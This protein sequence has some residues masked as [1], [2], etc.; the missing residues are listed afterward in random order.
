MPM[1]GET[2]AVSSVAYAELPSHMKPLRYCNSCRVGMMATQTSTSKG[3]SKGSLQ[4]VTAP[5]RKPQEED[6]RWRR[7]PL[8]APLGEMSHRGAVREKVALDSVN[9][10]G[11]PM[12]ALS[13]SEG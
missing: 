12:R 6:D 1:T 3:P 5:P 8:T 2:T 9:Q 10:V 11:Q 13:L 4:P 7:N